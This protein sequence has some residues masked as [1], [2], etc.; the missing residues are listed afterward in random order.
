M[1]EYIAIII[2]VYILVLTGGLKGPLNALGISVLEGCYIL[3]CAL[4]LSIFQ[5]R[6]GMEIS[7]NL[8]AL[9]LTFMPGYMIRKT[10]TDSA[11]IGAVM[12]ISLLAALL[13]D[14][15]EL[16]G[17]DSGLL[18]GLM[19]G[20]SAFVC[21]GNPSAAAYAAGSIPLISAAMNTFITLIVSGYASVEIE[22]DI[23]A[24]Q[25]IALCIST[26]IIWVNDLLPKRAGI[27]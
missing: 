20:M 23:I 8:A 6:I 1:P 9:L 11:G 2:C 18:C 14:N 10:D 26:V 12:L 16:Y 3:L 24:A 21:A 25:L 15:G 5:L 4:A 22:H 27:E 13:K 17:A 7:I 19:A